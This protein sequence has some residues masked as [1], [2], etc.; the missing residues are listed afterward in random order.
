MR[1]LVLLSVCTFALVAGCKKTNDNN[2]PADPAAKPTQAEPAAA[3]K[4]EAPIELTDTV[5]LGAAITD[6]DQTAFKGLKAKAPKGAKTE[7]G[8]TGVLIRLDD[9]CAF[10][11][12]KAFEPGAVAK[13]KQEAQDD[14][15]DKLVKFHLDT[16]TAVLWETASEL[17]GE[18]N[19][20][21]AAE[22]KV[23]DAAYKCA[24]SG[25]GNFTK[26]RAEALLKSCQSLSK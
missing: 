2:Q 7:P 22:V 12:S 10:E 23:G 8:L 19:F 24:N 15:L 11:I 9:H 14:K 3:P 1:N 17:G 5:D 20:H 21:F 4:N 13:A 16:P 25:Y 18:N 6:P 26:A